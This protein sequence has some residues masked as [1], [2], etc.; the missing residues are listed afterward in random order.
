MQIIMKWLK[1]SCKSALKK[2]TKQQHPN[3]HYSE[4]PLQ[5]KIVFTLICPPGQL[6]HSSVI[7]NI[8]GMNGLKKE[9]LKFFNGVFGG[10]IFVLDYVAVKHLSVCCFICFIDSDDI[11]LLWKKSQRK[12]M[13]KAIFIFSR[14]G[15]ICRNGKVSDFTTVTGCLH[16]R[17]SVLCKTW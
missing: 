15:C 17:L 11:L 2:S 7:L 3:P 8:H 14:W 5:N 4:G 6:C 12:K 13:Q 16:E 10:V 9:K 1:K